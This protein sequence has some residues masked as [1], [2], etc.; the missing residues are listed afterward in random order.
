MKRLTAYTKEGKGLKLTPGSPSFKKE[1]ELIFVELEQLTEEGNFLLFILDRGEGFQELTGFRL[2]CLLCGLPVQ[3]AIQKI[4]YIEETIR[5]TAQV[6]CLFCHCCT[7]ST[8]LFVWWKDTGPN[9][10]CQVLK[11]KVKRA[12]ASPTMACRE[13]D[14]I[15]EAVVGISGG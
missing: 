8:C 3:F 10:R 14:D 12:T 15:R 6:S 9:G 5:T 1:A 11:R 2:R 7:L 4:P 13:T